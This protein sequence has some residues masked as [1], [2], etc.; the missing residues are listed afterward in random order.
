MSG[1]KPI[2]TGTFAAGGATAAIK[3]GCAGLGTGRTDCYRSQA[4]ANINLRGTI[5][6]ERRQAGKFSRERNNSGGAWRY[7]TN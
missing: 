1:G 5:C 3:C 6:T 7:A 4:T 2:W